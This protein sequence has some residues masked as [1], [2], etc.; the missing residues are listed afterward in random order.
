MIEALRSLRYTVGDLVLAENWYNQWLDVQPYQ[1]TD[2]SLRYCVDGSWLELVEANLPSANGLLVYWGVDSL[3]HEL[4]RL[5]AVGISPQTPPSLQ[6]AGNAS[7]TFEDPFGNVVG[8]IEIHDPNAQRAR[9][10][11]A[12]EKIAL[13]KVRETLD[14]LSEEDRQQRLANR[15]VL[16][17]VVLALLVGGFA[18]VKMLPHTPQEDK[19][20]IPLTGKK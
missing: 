9:A 8:L 20:T 15:L 12:A 14:N 17:L 1:R 18:V 13:R 6:G 11:R 10:H 5:H 16:A 4:Q 19:I 2:T 3:V 7:A